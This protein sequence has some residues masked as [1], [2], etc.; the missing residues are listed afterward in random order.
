MTPYFSTIMKALISVSDKAGIVEF[1]TELSNL[2][3]EILSTG[4][5]AKT[6]RDASIK[7]T[8]VSEY[9]GSPEIMDGR[10]KTLH[11]KIHGGLLA[12]RDNESHVQQAKD[13][14]ID[15]I[16]LVVVNLYPF[17]QTIAKENVTQAEAIE[18]IDIGGP[19]ML[20]SAAK[21]FK[22]VTVIVDPHDYN[23]VLDEIK[24]DKV[25]EETRA[26]LA[27]KVFRHTADYDAAIDK[28]L[29][30][31]LTNEDILRLKFTNGQK[32]RY[33]ENWHQQATFYK[34]ETTESSLANAEIL[35]GKE[36]SYNNYIDAD[37]ALEAVKEL[38]DTAAVAIVKHTNTC[39]LATGSNLPEAFEKAW[40][41][42][43]ISAFGSVIAVTK[44]VDTRSAEFL[45]GKFVEALIAP[46]FSDEALEFLKNKSKDIRLIKI[47][48]LFEPKEKNSYRSIVGGMLEQNR[49]LQTYKE[50]KTVTKK[51]FDK[52][53]L[54]E[55]A[56]KACKHVKS[57]AIILAYEYE[58]GKFMILGM[59][60]G[61]PNR[62]DALKKLAV[63]KATENLKLMGLPQETLND[64]VLASDAFF[65]FDDTVREAASHGITQIIQPGGSKKDDE[66]IAACDELE[67][68][69]IFTEMRHFR[70]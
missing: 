38:K 31:Q 63:T 55:F 42:D 35:H 68:A 39:G 17:Q 29:S 3:Y 41:G 43:P 32:L 49:D 60:A 28:Y 25:S 7:V 47:P 14:S 11:P 46:G 16:D 21:N 27:V 65:P 13:N 4:G 64:C 57:N 54:A 30:K 66:V 34:K 2:N 18:N 37:A 5:T 6:L 26:K 22:H 36:M 69:M 20:R 19:A 9:T 12:L 10:V 45:Q 33:G 8:D 24:Q 61:Q 50:W 1:A 52:T 62:I 59:G 44:T 53:D 48:E 15:M 67:M 40:A 51:E 58:L 56:F 70:H 23:K